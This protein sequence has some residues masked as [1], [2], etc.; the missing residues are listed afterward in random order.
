MLKYCKLQ[1]KFDK[2]T[3]IVYNYKKNGGEDVE[4]K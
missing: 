1:L 2:K 3:R 4:Y